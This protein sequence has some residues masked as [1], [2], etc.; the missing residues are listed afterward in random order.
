MWREGTFKPYSRAS[1][2]NCS[3]VSPWKLYGSMLA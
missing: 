3:A 2:S 1:A